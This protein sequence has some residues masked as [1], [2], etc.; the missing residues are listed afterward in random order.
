MGVRSLASL[1]GLRILPCRELWCRSQT[2]L[3]SLA[4]LWPWRRLATVAPIGPLAWELPYAACVA[5]K[6]K[7]KIVLN[8]IKLQ[9]SKQTRKLMHFRGKNSILFIMGEFENRQFL[10]IK[11]RRLRRNILPDRAGSL[12][13][14][15][16]SMAG[17]FLPQKTRGM[18]SRER[19][20]SFLRLVVSCLSP[21]GLWNS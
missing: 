7:K 9:T 10:S 4:L 8:I 1:S 20:T 11:Q 5:L 12:Q 3:G 2:Q 6:R 21:E 17:G 13:G 15:G 14:I 18:W 19:Q 16:L